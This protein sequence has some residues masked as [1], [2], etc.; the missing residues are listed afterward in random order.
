MHLLEKRKIWIAL[1][2]AELQRRRRYNWQYQARP[3]QQIPGKAWHTWLI[4]AGRGFGKTRTGAE[5]IRCWATKGHYKNI[6]LIAASLGE[7]RTIMVEGQSGLLNI[8]TEEECP[9]YI[10][11]RRQLHWKNGAVA[12]LFGAEAYEQLR[13]P[14]FDCAWIDE[15]AK[16]RKAE[17]VWQQ[18]QLCLRLGSDPRCIITTTPR[19]IKLIEQ[20]IKT[21]G[22]VTTRGTTFDNAENLAPGFLDHIQKQFLGTRLGAQELY[23]E[24][25]TQ[26]AGALWHR[27]MILYQQ[28]PENAD[29]TLKLERIVIAIDPATTHHEGSDETGIIIAGLDSAKQAYVLEDLS[30][31]FSPGDWGQRVVAAYWRHRADRVVAEVNKGGDLVERILTS[32]DPSIAFK[33]VR[34]TRGKQTRAEPI[35]AL[36]EQRRVFHQRPLTALESQLCDYV[37]GITSKSPD[38]LDAMVW[39]ITDL[40]L[41]NERSGQFKIWHARADKA[42]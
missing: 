9:K 40:L 28:P 30:G 34:A 16:F 10:P 41:E 2:E 18:L 23:A 3:N 11:T 25:L 39:A 21:P 31:K 36:Y 26:T 17:F 13:G 12:T 27:D 7:A 4:M 22:V 15:L 5:T 8:H 35:A 32:I 24:L 20:L 37:P 14:Q 6:A 33:A 42:D 29:G 1:L 19:P 38:R